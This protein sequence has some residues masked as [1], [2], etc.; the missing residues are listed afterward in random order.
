MSV[1]SMNPA[2]R[3]AQVFITVPFHDIDSVGIA[4]HG[5][6]AKYFEIARCELLESFG[7]GYDA[8]RASGYIWPIIDLR[9]RYIKPMRFNQRIAVTAS[10]REW[11]NRLLID[12]LVT[13]ATSGERLTK[14]HTSQVAVDS[15]SG[16]MCFVSPSILFER[17]GIS[18]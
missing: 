14:G 17:L 3:R 10:L 18:R 8:M 5:H 2:E 15:K 9:V 4:W 11:E 1:N 12:Y 6:Y 16:E 13:D 7:Y